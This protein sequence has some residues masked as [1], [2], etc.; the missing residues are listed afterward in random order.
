[1]VAFKLLLLDPLNN[2]HHYQAIMIQIVLF[3]SEKLPKTFPYSIILNEVIRQND[4]QLINAINELCK[5]FPT[6]ETETFLRSLQ[7]PLYHSIDYTIFIFGT[8]FDVNFY[9]HDKLV[10]LP[11]QL[12]VFKSNDEGDLKML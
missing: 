6:Y 9:N 1:M 2:Y 7:H 5:G 12:H 3:L 11:F 10:A 8:N 4:I